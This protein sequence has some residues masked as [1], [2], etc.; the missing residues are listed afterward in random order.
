LALAAA[1]AVVSG[2][3]VFLNGYGVR[4]WSDVADPTTYTSI[5]NVVTALVVAAWGVAAAGRRPATTPTRPMTRRDRLMLLFVALVGGSVPFVLFF[6]GL[7]RADSAQ[8][9]FIHKTLVIW[10][11]VLAVSLLRERVGMPHLA[12]IGLLVWG[13]IALVGGVGGVTLGGGEMMILAATLLW[14]LE[15]VLAK[16][17]LADLPYTTVAKARMIG[18]SAL[19]VAWAA[20]RGFGGIDWSAVTTTHIVWVTAAGLFLSAYVLTWLA[21][22]S[23]APAVDVTSVLVGGAVITA[24]LQTVVRGAPLP[25]VGALALI[26]T[27]VLFAGIASWRAPVTGSS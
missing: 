4:V 2:V 26:V 24:I 17:L 12:A 16:R 23:L 21:A 14:A 13:Q 1:T 7:A 3:A 25:D 10:V 6:E 19:L 5:K 18:G 9:A 22:L 8:A 20:V 11:P 27:G 15:V